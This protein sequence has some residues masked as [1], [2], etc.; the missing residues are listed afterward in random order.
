[1]EWRRA[2]IARLTTKL[3]LALCLFLA[4]T[5]GTFVASSASAANFTRALIQG[6][7]GTEVTALQQIL[8]DRGFLH[9]TPT[10]YFGPLTTKAVAAFQTAHNIAPLGGV[11]PLTRALLDS[12]PASSTASTTNETSVVSPAT[13]CT[14]SVVITRSLDLGS[15][16]SDVTGLQTFLVA[17]GYLTVAPTGY[18][19]TLTHAAVAKFQTSEGFDPIGIVGPLTRTK[20]AELTAACTQPNV[21]ITQTTGT[22]TITA[23][24]TTATTTPGTVTQPVAPGNGYTPG[25][26]G[27]GG[28]GGGGSSSATPADTAPVISSISSG[29]PGQTNAT[30]TWTTDENSNSK[31]VYGLTTGYGLASSSAS[32]I[33]SHSIYMSGL[34]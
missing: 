3:V 7:S 13:S 24:T 10:G 15:T 34:T 33:T 14:A 4:V 6:D 27:G 32:L 29:T 23:A 20:I 22:A 26:G 25:F 30:I 31:V 16:G 5:A 18:F 21:T 11:G 28:G 2:T 17:Q 9:V 19:G 1:M 8:Y 12:L